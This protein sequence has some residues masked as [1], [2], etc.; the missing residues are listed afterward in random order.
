MEMINVTT[1]KKNLLLGII[2][3]LIIGLFCTSFVIYQK[4]IDTSSWSVIINEKEVFIEGRETLP[5]KYVYINE[6][7]KNYIFSTSESLEK[8]VEEAN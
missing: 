3:L 5:F 7:N 8:I 4:K 2:T 1:I 6:K